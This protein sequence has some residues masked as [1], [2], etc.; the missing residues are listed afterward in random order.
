MNAEP[1]LVDSACDNDRRR[2][3]VITKIGSG[4]AR[5]L[6]EP[7]VVLAIPAYSAR[8]TGIHVALLSID[9]SGRNTHRPIQIGLCVQQVAD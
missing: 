6:T 7:S 2:Y 3:P 4:P 8:G 1:L 9:D 5:R